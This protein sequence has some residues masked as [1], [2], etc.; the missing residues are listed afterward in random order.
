VLTAESD[1]SV[2]V[3]VFA[4]YTHLNYYRM[5]LSELLSAISPSTINSVRGKTM[6]FLKITAI[7]GLTVALIACASTQIRARSLCRH[8][9]AQIAYLI[10]ASFGPQ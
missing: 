4:P 9:V 2:L 5:G 6:K 8:S 3:A 7:A 1:P 10:P